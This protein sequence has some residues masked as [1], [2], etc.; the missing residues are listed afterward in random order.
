MM[1]QQNEETESEQQYRQPTGRETDTTETQTAPLPELT[2]APAVTAFYAAQEKQ[3]TVST[4]YRVGEAALLT[5]AVG[6]L[7]LAMQFLW[8][9]ASNVLFRSGFST[10][11][12]M[13]FWFG[14][15]SFVWSAAV[16]IVVGSGVGLLAK[17]PSM[18][19]SLIAANVINALIWRI[20]QYFTMPHF[21]QA[22]WQFTLTL[23]VQ[24]LVG[25]ATIIIS[26]II[27]AQIVARKFRPANR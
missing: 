8:M 21:Y 15:V 25:L 17:R 26:E 27:I 12:G 14:L 6:A 10:G 9:L 5:V 16:V 1:L 13:T 19:G 22:G 23:L 3:H 11:N 24:G 7:S 4:A 2:H 18:V 20:V